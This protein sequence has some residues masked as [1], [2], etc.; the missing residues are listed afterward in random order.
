[1][2]VWDSI[3]GE[4][5]TLPGVFGIRIQVVSVEVDTGIV[6]MLITKDRLSEQDTLDPK[7]VVGALLELAG[8]RMVEPQ[9][10]KRPIAA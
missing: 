8:E 6:G 3:V 1:M 9:P 7:K 5:R 2:E 4:D 10:P